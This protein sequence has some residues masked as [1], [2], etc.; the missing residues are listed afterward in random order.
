MRNF[1]LY[2]PKEL[3]YTIQLAI[4]INE[5]ISKRFHIVSVTV[6]GKRVKQWKMRRDIHGEKNRKRAREREREREEKKASP[7]YKVLA[8][9]EV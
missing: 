5:A 8:E 1:Y 6:C 4:I 7:I 9:S 3:I 2:S